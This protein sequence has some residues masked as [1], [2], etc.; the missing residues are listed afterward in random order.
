MVTLRVPKSIRTESRPHCFSIRIY[1]MNFAV[2]SS[3]PKTAVDPLK[4]EL[5]AHFKYACPLSGPLFFWRLADFPQNPKSAG[6][7]KAYT[8]NSEPRW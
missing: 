6:G 5:A 8:L 4:A 1:F 7:E 3:K 2:A